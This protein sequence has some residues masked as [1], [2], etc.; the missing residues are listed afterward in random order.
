MKQQQES[1]LSI[2]FLKLTLEVHKRLLSVYTLLVQFRINLL[3]SLYP[4]PQRRR[5]T[6]CN[7]T[8]LDRCRASTRSTS[9]V[10]KDRC[11]GRSG[12]GADALRT[13]T[14]RFQLADTVEAAPPGIHA[15]AGNKGRRNQK[16]LQASV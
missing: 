11:A 3:L 1:E 5:D 9:Q 15:L 14:I 7:D 16:T 13:D 6:S 2:K 8:P 4:R 10:R 12:R